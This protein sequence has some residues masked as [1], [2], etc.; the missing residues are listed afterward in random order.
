MYWY[1]LLEGDLVSKSVWP[2]QLWLKRVCS[3]KSLFPFKT[4]AGALLSS[5]VSMKETAGWAFSVKFQSFCASVCWNLNDEKTWVSYKVKMWKDKE[6]WYYAEHTQ[7]ECAKCKVATA[8]VYIGQ[9]R[10]IHPY[11]LAAATDSFDLLLKVGLKK[12]NFIN[13]A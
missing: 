7:A 8:I 9:E 1:Y 2:Y 4:P 3:E 5:A 12:L 6:K 11:N 10:I 13:H